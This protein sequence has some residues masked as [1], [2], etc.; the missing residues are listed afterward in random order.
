MQP[1]SYVLRTGATYKCKFVFIDEIADLKFIVV[2]IYFINTTST[3][4]SLPEIEE[5]LYFSPYVHM[6]YSGLKV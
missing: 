6:L 2:H 3:L 1:E 5:K 4:T